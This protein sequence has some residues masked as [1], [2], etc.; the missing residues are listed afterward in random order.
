MSACLHIMVI[1]GTIIWES[2]CC[3][4]GRAVVL[5]IA[6]PF[7]GS[8]CRFGFRDANLGVALP[9]WGS[10]C[11][12]GGRAA[13]L[14]VCFAVFGGDAAN[15]GVALPF[16]LVRLYPFIPQLFAVFFVGGGGGV[17]LPFWGSRC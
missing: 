5:E 6:P 16:L 10:R 17:D 3:F 9:F 14:G 8:R 13:V 11:K 12:F 1:C 4:G 15:L 7:W 2:R